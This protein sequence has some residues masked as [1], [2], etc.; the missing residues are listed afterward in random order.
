MTPTRSPMT[1]WKLHEESKKYPPPSD[2][3]HQSAYI[4]VR[5]ILEQNIE[6][7]AWQ[8]GELMDSIKIKLNM[9]CEQDKRAAMLLAAIQALQEALDDR[10]KDL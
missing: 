6:W 7:Y 8:Y 9:T 2:A 1:V 5:K 10:E 4:A 3:Y